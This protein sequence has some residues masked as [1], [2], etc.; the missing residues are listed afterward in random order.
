MTARIIWSTFSSCS[1]TREIAQ[2][3]FLFFI[4]SRWIVVIFSVWKESEDAR[5]VDIRSWNV[6]TI[7]SKILKSHCTKTR[8]F[9]F[10]Y[11]PNRVVSTV[12]ELRCPKISKQFI[13]K[14]KCLNEWFVR[15]LE[16]HVVITCPDS[17]QPVLLVVLHCLSNRIHQIWTM[18]ERRREDDAPEWMRPRDIGRIQLSTGPWS[19]CTPAFN[20]IRDPHNP[21]LA[22]WEGGGPLRQYFFSLY[23][24]HGPLQFIVCF[25]VF[26]LI[27][28]FNCFGRPPLGRGHVPHVM[29]FFVK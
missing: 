20:F 15:Q 12:W 3:Y 4:L 24:T 13:P 21:F 26:N 29:T 28:S 6:T 1:R 11:F 27:F 17:K 19:V 8:F 25:I 22:F 7:E 16:K 5:L 2:V 14:E 18:T 9:L 10:D 23:K